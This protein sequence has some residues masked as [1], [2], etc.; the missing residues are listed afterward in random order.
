MLF[1]DTKESQITTQMTRRLSTCLIQAGW[2]REGKYS[3]GS[4]RNQARFVRS[5]EDIANASD[6]AAQEDYNFWQFINASVRMSFLRKHDYFC[7]LLIYRNY[8]H[9]IVSNENSCAYS[10]HVTSYKENPCASCAKHLSNSYPQ[11]FFENIYPKTKNNPTGH[12]LV[13]LVTQKW[14]NTGR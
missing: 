14:T 5:A 10:T 2:K 6:I 12:S 3:S 13:T 8:L 7:K 11:L 4:Q 1:Q 9:P